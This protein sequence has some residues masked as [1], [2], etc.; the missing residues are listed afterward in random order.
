MKGEGVLRGRLPRGIYG[1]S[2][3]LVASSLAMIV[4]SLLPPPAIHVTILGVAALFATAGLLMRK[5]WGFLLGLFV[6]ILYI[7]FG[8]SLLRALF[9]FFQFSLTPITTA[10][11]MMVFAFIVATAIFSFYILSKRSIFG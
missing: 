1:A 2:A 10:L 4:L 11:L 8:L 3:F 7:A 5:R 9:L 6:L